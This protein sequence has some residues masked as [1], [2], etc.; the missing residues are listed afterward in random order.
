MS[1]YS[2]AARAGQLLPPRAHDVARTLGSGLEGLLYRVDR[3]VRPP[4]PPLRVL[5]WPGARGPKGLSSPRAPY[6]TATSR[7]LA[8][9]GYHVVTDPARPHDLGLFYLDETDQSARVPTGR[10]VINGRCDDISK[11]RVDSVWAA[12]SG[13]TT[14]VDPASHHGPVLRKPD[15]NSR[16]GLCVVEC[17]TEPEEGYVYQRLIHTPAPD[18]TRIEYRLPVYGGRIPLCYIRTKAPTEGP[19]SKTFSSTAIADPADHFSDDELGLFRLF[20]D[21]FGVDYAEVDVLRGSDGVAHPVDVNTTPFMARTFDKEAETEAIR[22][23]A[24]AFALLCEETAAAASA[25]L[26]P[27]ES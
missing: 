26:S 14:L 15:E 12:V 17:P 27:L 10:P 9:C 20:A 18:G 24:P 19:G 2:V 8:A 23:L 16:R 3:G 22:R 6:T 11:R 5:V 4:G 7:L 13:H 25:S 1:L 21:A